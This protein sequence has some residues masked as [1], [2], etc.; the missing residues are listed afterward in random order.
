MLMGVV[1]IGS[2]TRAQS[3]TANSATPD[4][5]AALLPPVEVTGHAPMGLRAG[6]ACKS[7]LVGE[8]V[9]VT[10][11]AVAREGRAAKLGVLKGDELIAI[12]GVTLVGKKKS[13]VYALME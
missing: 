4:N 10:V 5:S 11:P 13:E 7:I 2:F 3:D 8:V 9:R 6:I 1:L 12:N